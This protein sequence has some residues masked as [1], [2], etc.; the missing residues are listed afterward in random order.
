[1]VGGGS[2][3]KEY[4]WRKE[5]RLEKA[6]REER[7]WHRTRKTRKQKENEGHTR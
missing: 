5:K 4:I 6:W 2:G 3:G 1:M 7:G